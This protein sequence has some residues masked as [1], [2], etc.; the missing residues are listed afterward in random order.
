M[1]VELVDVKQEL[2]VRRAVDDGALQRV[3]VQ[4]VRERAAVVLV[5]LQWPG[6]RV[7]AL[8]LIFRGASD[9]DERVNDAGPGRL[10]L[11]RGEQRGV[12]RSRIGTGLREVKDC[13]RRRGGGER[14]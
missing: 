4:A 5:E 3:E 6:V 7:V 13:V 8:H 14:Q 12:D 2:V 9:A 1:A 10:L 11:R